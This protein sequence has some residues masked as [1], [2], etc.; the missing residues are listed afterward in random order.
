MAD[1][2]ASATSTDAP[3]AAAKPS[4]V[5]LAKLASNYLV[6]DIPK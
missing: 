6:G 4:A 3:A 5:E 2:S 1:T